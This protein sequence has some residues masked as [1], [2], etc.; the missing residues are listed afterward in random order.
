VINLSGFERFTRIL[1]EGFWLLALGTIG[2]FAFF[3]ALGAFDP[4]DVKW[5]TVVVAVLLVLFALRMVAMRRAGAA[6]AMEERK[7]HERERRGF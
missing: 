7:T 1:G 3:A 5:L 2:I 4:S 6:L